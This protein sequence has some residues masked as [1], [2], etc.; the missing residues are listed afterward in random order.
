MSRRAKTPEPRN[1]IS[2]LICEYGGQQPLP[3]PCEILCDEHT[4][5]ELA[6]L[7]SDEEDQSSENEENSVLSDEEWRSSEEV[8][9]ETIFSMS[10][11]FV[12]VRRVYAHSLCTNVY[13][14]IDKKTQ[15][16]MAVKI[17][18]QYGNEDPVEVRVL[19]KLNGVANCQQIAAFYRFPDC[20]VMVS[21]FYQ[22]HS[23]RKTIW[24]NNRKIRIFMFQLMTV[25]KQIHSQKIIHRDVKLSN[26]MW[27]DDTEILTLLD[28]D[29]STFNRKNHTKYAGTEG[30]EAPEMI[31][32]HKG[33]KNLTYD[34]KI[35]IYSAGVILGGL[36]YKCTEMETDRKKTKKWKMKCR[37]HA[38]PVKSLFLKMVSHDQR[39]RPSAE[40]ILQDI[41]FCNDTSNRK[42]KS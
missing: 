12:F 24:G 32:I 8:I 34:E 20:N 27:D 1:V 22:E 17:Q 16:R 15:N 3:I 11:H 41:Y 28:F 29:L 25:L 39:D 5:G 36:L 35:D 19:S 4:Y 40:D 37:K 13:L 2:E 18:V 38:S 7:D 10:Y 30:Y 31:Q 42:K 9:E 23:I 21:P 6:D 14:A 33:A 26:I